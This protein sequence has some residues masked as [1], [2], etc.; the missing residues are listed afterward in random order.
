[1]VYYGSLTILILSK[2]V[3]IDKYV[4]Q[5]EIQQQTLNELIQ[6]NANYL[7]TIRKLRETRIKVSTPMPKLLCEQIAI[8]YEGH[9]LEGKLHKSVV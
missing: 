7:Q 5:K 3:T 1:M 9:Y 8:L 4:R 2:V 6:G